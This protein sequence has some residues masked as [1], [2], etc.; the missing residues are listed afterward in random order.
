[1]QTLSTPSQPRFAA[2]PW[3][4]LGAIL[5]IWGT[6]V[7]ALAE[8]GA[9]RQGLG[10]PP[11]RLMAAIAGPVLAGVLI[12]RFVPGVREWTDRWD[13]ATLVSLQTFR[14]VG[15]VFLFFWWIGTLPTIFAWVAALG[16][17]AVG[18]LAIPT[19]LA[20]A[21]QTQGWQAKVRRLTWFG[22]ADF[23]AVLVLATLSPEGRILHFAG[24]PT[25]AAMQVMPMI[26]IP[27]FLVPIFILLLLLQRQRVKS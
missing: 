1:M 27:G 19:T 8:A 2:L 11:L 12:Y 16:D 18:I 10:L 7:L 17:I 15:V 24:E 6:G 4:I 23:A 22:I 3:V 25:P 13:L 20:V 14:V 26:M 5:L 21:R 9:F